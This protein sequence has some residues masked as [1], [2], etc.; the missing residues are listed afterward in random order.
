MTKSTT[1]QVCLLIDFENLVRGAADFAGDD[2]LN[3][4]IDVKPLCRL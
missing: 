2:R 3:E 4:T 1:D